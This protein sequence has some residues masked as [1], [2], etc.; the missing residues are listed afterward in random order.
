VAQQ[1]AA[2]L[3]RRFGADVVWLPFD[4]HPEYPPGGLLREQLVAR[5]GE[6]GLARTKAMFEARGLDYNPN[7]DVVP[8]TQAVLR[9]GEHA[10]GH[11]LHHAFHDRVM[12]AYWAEARNIGDPDELRAL[13]A[14]VGLP[15]E[16]VDVVLA[17]D[18]Y[19]DVVESSTAQAV[20]IGVTGVPAFVLDH[21]LLVP[22]AQ[23]DE[24][25]DQAF[26]QLAAAG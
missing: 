5:Y 13:A 18:R 9:L 21:R 26:A 11:G 3:E 17:G 2:R 10:R 24:V 12:D 15:A 25:F 22:G 20:S 19:L 1:T 16:E 4:L 7:P 23:P 14:D 6:A 8:N